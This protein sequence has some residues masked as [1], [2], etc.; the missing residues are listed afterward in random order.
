MCKALDDLWKDGV[1]EGKA[2]L[3]EV[4]KEL[5]AERKKR[6]LAEDKI[7]EIVESLLQSGQSVREVSKITRLSENWVR[8]TARDR[9][10]TL[11]RGRAVQAQ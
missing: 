4:K 3:E 7:R 9:G 8:N 6:R 2:N 1:K 5:K 11:V 10:I